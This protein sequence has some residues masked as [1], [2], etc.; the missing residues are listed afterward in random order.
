[1]RKYLNTSS[2]PLSLSVF[3]ATDNYDRDSETISVTTLLKPLKQIVLGARVPPEE[4]LID[5]SAIVSS[6]LGSAIHDSIERAWLNGH[7]EAMAALGYPQR[8]IDNVL[9]NPEPHEL[10][11][12]CIPVYLERRSSKVIAGRTVSGKFDFVGEGRLEDFKNTTV[13]TY[14]NSSKDDAYVMQ[15]SMYRWLNPDIITADTMAIQYIFTDWSQAQAKSS[16]KYP[17]TRTLEKVYRLKSIQET[18]AFVSNKIRLIDTYWNADESAMPPCTDADLW[19]KEPQWKYYKNPEKT[20]RST[21]NFDNKQDAYIH[22]AQ[23]GNVGIVKEVP[24]QVVACKY[25]PA[26]AI[27][28]QKDALIASGD[29][30]F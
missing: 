17:P 21:K 8:V 14:T 1:M 20:A 16:A 15:G 26:F 4:A 18:E 2:I 3:L 25:C 9:V 19:R 13:F 29:L 12:G 22:M 7:K 27:C 30:I 24:G 6:R 28:K 11:D 10:Y 23:D 5:I